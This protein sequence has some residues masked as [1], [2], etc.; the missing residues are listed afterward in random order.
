[1]SNERLG[2]FAEGANKNGSQTTCLTA[3]L[4]LT[5]KALQRELDR[6]SCIDLSNRECGCNF[7]HRPAIIG[8]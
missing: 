2:K 1:M 3:V 8:E 7:W 4:S 5:S 6:Y